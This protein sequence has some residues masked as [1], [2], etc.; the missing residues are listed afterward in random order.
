MLIFR[1][2]TNGYVQIFTQSVSEIFI[3]RDF[4]SVCFAFERTRN[5]YA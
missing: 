5:A 3:L 4:Y 1:T 2:Q